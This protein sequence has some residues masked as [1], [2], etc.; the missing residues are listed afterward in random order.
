MKEGERAFGVLRSC[1]TIVWHPA[2]TWSKETICEVMTACVIMR[3]MIV[4]EERDE[5]VYDQGLG[6]SG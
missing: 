3:N 2:R 5:S 1:W 4:E 6:I